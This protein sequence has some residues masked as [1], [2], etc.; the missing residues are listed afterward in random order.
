MKD[1]PTEPTVE[2]TD[3]SKLRVWSAMEIEAW[4]DYSLS[5]ALEMQQVTMVDYELLK[6]TYPDPDDEIQKTMQNEFDQFKYYKGE[7]KS[8]FKLQDG[9]LNRGWWAFE[10]GYA[11]SVLAD[12]IPMYEYFKFTN[13][14]SQYKYFK[15][16]LDCPFKDDSG[17]EI[18]DK[19]R[20]W[21]LEKFHWNV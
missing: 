6:Y 10:K 16:E 8:P 17:N 4:G 3:K 19:S 18:W 5:E 12:K 7:E 9:Y 1:K 2:L 20:W 21:E 14:F 13:D 11:Q 15:G